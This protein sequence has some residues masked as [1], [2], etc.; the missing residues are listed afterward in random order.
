LGLY[1]FSAGLYGAYLVFKNFSLVN[2]MMGYGREPNHQSTISLEN[3]PRGRGAFLLMLGA[4]RPSLAIA[5]T[6]TVN[7]ATDAN[8]PLLCNSRQAIY[9]HNHSKAA[10]LSSCSAGTLSGN[11]T[12]DLKI[13]GNTVDLANKNDPEAPLT[14]QGGSVEI[15]PD[16]KNVCYTL[17]QATYLT[18]DPG[19]T[20]TLTRIS[21]VV[22]GA[23]SR[24]AIENNGGTLT[25]QP[26][27]NSGACLFSNQGGIGDPS[28]FGGILFNHSFNQVAGHRH[29]HDCKRQL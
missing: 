12:I 21:V 29:H 5:T 26:D 25:I 22:N 24:S 13:I 4:E 3:F 27:G 11:D 16:P 17:Q 1:G 18:V 10:P 23:A 20:M 6:I 19:A 28:L 15:K 8:I 14:I 2:K 7:N 9:S